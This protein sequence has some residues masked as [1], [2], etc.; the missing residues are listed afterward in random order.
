MM[1]RFCYSVLFVV[2]II[3]L[4][5]S[6][7]SSLSGEDKSAIADAVFETVVALLGESASEQSVS[8]SSYGV[9]VSSPI[10][11]V[12]GYS[13]EELIVL[14]N[15]IDRGEPLP[16]L[17]YGLSSLQASWLLSFYKNESDRVNPAI[18]MYSAVCDKSNWYVV[19]DNITRFENRLSLEMGLDPDYA[20]NN[21]EIIDSLRTYQSSSDS[22]YKSLLGR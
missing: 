20:R 14:E 6:G 17:R 10:I 7:C 13:E 4:M 11:E 16:S 5:G 19:Y 15:L 12:C 2:I 22:K 1:S 3:G 9:R 18:T 8:T 21:A